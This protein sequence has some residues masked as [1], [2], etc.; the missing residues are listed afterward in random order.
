MYSSLAVPYENH[1]CTW[2]LPPI[3]LKIPVQNTGWEGG[4]GRGHPPHTLQY[5][6]PLEGVGPET[7]VHKITNLPVLNMVLGLDD[8]YE[9]K[10][11]TQAIGRGGP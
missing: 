1:T 7:H 8:F 2:F 11:I 3:L 6:W 9:V 10:S 5:Q 4:D